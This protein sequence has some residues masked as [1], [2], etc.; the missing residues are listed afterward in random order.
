MN[1]YIGQVRGHAGKF[2]TEEQAS[3]LVRWA[4]TV[5]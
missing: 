3:I 1:G 4:E 2:F 5:Y